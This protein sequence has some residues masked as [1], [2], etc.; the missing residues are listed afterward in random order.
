MFSELAYNDFD[1]FCHNL[2][3]FDVGGK[4]LIIDTTDFSQVDFEGHIET[5]RL[6]MDT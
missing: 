3:A 6:F 2:D 5:A 1:R 4:K